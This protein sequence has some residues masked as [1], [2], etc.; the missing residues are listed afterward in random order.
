MLVALLAVAEM[1]SLGLPS[2]TLLAACLVATAAAFSTP[3]PASPMRRTVRC[4]CIQRTR[5]PLFLLQDQDYSHVQDYDHTPQFDHARQMPEVE[6][7]DR[8]SRS[9]SRSIARRQWKLQQ[10]EEYHRYAADGL[11]DCEREQHEEQPEYHSN[12]QRDPY[13]YVQAQYH[14][15]PVSP[16]T[17]RGGVAKEWEAIAI[18]D[19]A[20]DE[21]W[22]GLRML[23]DQRGVS[24]GARARAN[25]LLAAYYGYARPGRHEYDGYA[26]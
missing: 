2:Q 21:D 22:V 5:E 24:V 16:M 9:L 10:Q 6:P 1:P 13:G 3:T 8:H 23:A 26:A 7:D 4:G 11:R 18:Q 19:L 15:L 14:Q 20:N 12:A 17:S 25:D